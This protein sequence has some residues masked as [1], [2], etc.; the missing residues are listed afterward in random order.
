ME[1]DGF[2][3]IDVGSKELVVKL[4]LSNQ[5]N[6]EKIFTNNNDGHS[7]LIKWLKSNGKNCKQLL[8]L[9][10]NFYIVFGVCL[11][12]SSHLIAVDFTL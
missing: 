2:V 10:E 7:H 5:A 12:M 11:N 8:L 3:G 4:I 6:S 9:C 1:Q